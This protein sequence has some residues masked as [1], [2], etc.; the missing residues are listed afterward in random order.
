MPPADEQGG[1][2]YGDEIMIAHLSGTL[3]GKRGAAVII[4]V[5]GVG[6]EV[7][8][9]ASTLL[10]LPKDGARIKLY[11]TESTAMYG[12]ATTLY[13]F[14]SEEERDVFLLLKDEV[15]GA[16]AKKTLEYLEKIGMSIP[17]FRRAV[18]N[19]D[20]G[21][22]V[23][24]F[25]FTKKTADKLIAAL[26]DKTGMITLPSKE[27]AGARRADGPRAEAISGLI[28]LGYKENQSREA[29]DSAMDAAQGKLNVQE[30]IRLAL[31]QL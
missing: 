30:I 28:A 29:V 12:G 22:L 8:V 24:I 31:R 14:L 15:P 1:G 20:A 5:G 2:A 19:K 9:P 16:G 21:V 13:G 7:F 27:Q 10:S 23:S 4:D 17:E 11:I 6:Y 26:K 18:V 3:E 25:G